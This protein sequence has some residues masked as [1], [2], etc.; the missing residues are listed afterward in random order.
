MRLRAKPKHQGY[1][2]SPS[3]L[4]SLLWVKGSGT[5]LGRA[6]QHSKRHHGLS[7]VA[8]YLFGWDYLDS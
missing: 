3:L 7:W 5:P 4:P 8:S 6:G 1:S 2:R